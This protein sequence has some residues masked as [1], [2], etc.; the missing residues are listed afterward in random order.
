MVTSVTTT[1]TTIALTTTTAS[2][3]LIA[4]LTLIVLLIHKEIFSGL[5]GDRARQLSQALNVAIVPLSII[6]LATFILKI[7][8][9]L[10]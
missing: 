8:D 6:F 3:A 9:T 2:L 7:I 10:N 5:A 4:I 1:T